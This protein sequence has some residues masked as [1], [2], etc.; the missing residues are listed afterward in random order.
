MN[1][2]DI[3]VGVKGAWVGLLAQNPLAGSICITIFVAKFV[4]GGLVFFV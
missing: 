3:M 2:R 4:A 1:D